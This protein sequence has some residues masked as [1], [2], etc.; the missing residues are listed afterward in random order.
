VG[1]S[2]NTFLGQGAGAGN[3][4]SNSNTFIGEAAGFSSTGINNIALGATAGSALTTGNGN[5]CIGHTGV[6]ADANTI[7]IG[8]S[9]TQ[10]A[11]FVAGISGAT[12]AN[13]VAVQINTVTG[14]LGTIASSRRFKENIAEMGT[15]SS[16]LL[17]LRPVT[18]N[19]KKDESHTPQWGLIAEEVAAINPELVVR[20]EKG[21]IFTVRYEQINAMLLNEF[22][23]AHATIEGQQNTIA[24]QKTLLEALA[25]SVKA[26]DARLKVLETLLTK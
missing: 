25:A 9:G 23:K 8:T 5:I 11:A 4:S 3:V 6:A 7:R 12:V 14:Q 17:K 24:D 15:S 22:L 1:G 2:N 16:M 10:T 19:Y 21:E 26:Q 13:N 18:F 20:D